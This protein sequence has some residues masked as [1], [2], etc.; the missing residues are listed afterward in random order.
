MK[1]TALALALSFGLIG[2]AF[3]QTAPTAPAKPH[4]QTTAPAQA[5]AKP[6]TKVDCHKAENKAK[7]ECKASDKKS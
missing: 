2:A 4:A 7:A 6:A 1:T 3:A 5:Q